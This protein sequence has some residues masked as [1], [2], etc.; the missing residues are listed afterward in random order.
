VGDNDDTRELCAAGRSPGSKTRCGGAR[1][2]PG[3]PYTR[4]ETPREKVVVRIWQELLKLVRV[5]IN[6]NFFAPRGNSATILQL[7]LRLWAAFKR[8]LPAAALFR[9]PTI[10]SFLQFLDNEAMVDAV[11][12]NEITASVSVIDETV[13][14]W[15]DFI[16]ND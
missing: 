4:A 12:D 8:D 6:D 13:G 14:L 7:H 1:L 9:Y 10:K 16:D 5:G 3:T 11:R 2:K 15:D